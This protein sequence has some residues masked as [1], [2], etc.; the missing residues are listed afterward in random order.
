MRISKC[1]MNGR[2]GIKG[3]RDSC[4]TLMVVL[5]LLIQGSGGAYAENWS[6]PNE[7]VLATCSAAFGHQVEVT[8]KMSPEGAGWI[9]LKGM[10]KVDGVWKETL[11]KNDLCFTNSTGVSSFKLEKRDL[12]GDG[13]E[14][15]LLKGKTEEG[16]W[17]TVF[18]PTKSQLKK[19]YS[20][21]GVRVT[22]R[23]RGFTVQNFNYDYGVTESHDYQ[24]NSTGGLESVLSQPYVMGIRPGIRY[25]DFAEVLGKGG[26]KNYV[27]SKVL[28]ALNQKQF[29]LE[30]RDCEFT[31]QGQDLKDQ[32]DRYYLHKMKTNQPEVLGIGN[33][34][35]GQSLIQ[36]Q[37]YIDRQQAQGR[38]VPYSRFQINEVVL[39]SNENAIRGVTEVWK[40]KM[41]LGIIVEMSVEKE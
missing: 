17:L 26:K 31:F 32:K 19:L 29:T 38:P 41:K 22:M 3:F 16:E 10:Q 1:K 27:D 37:Q 28:K 2:Q 15:V 34:S 18:S 13:V 24:F 7:V 5:S 8:A 30:K 20:G 12:N 25:E 39:K 14:E 33:L 21:T 36:I 40:F 9:A 35:V 4:V 23:D 6:S 11:K